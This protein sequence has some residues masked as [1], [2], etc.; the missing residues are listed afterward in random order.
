M[1]K[2]S[3]TEK[4][5]KQLIKQLGDETVDYGRILELS[6]KLSELDEEN[7]RFSVDA[8][9]ISRLGRELV[10]RKESAVSELVKNAFDADATQVRLTFVEAELAG[11]RLLIED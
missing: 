5:R 6:L 9:H 8:S 7:V 1:A 10:V 4:I 11:G 2:D 3:S